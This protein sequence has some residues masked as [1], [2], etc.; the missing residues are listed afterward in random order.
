M[1]IFVSLFV[2]GFRRFACEAESSGVGQTM[3]KLQPHCVS[4]RGRCSRFRDVL[5]CERI[6]PRVVVSFA[7]P[8]VIALPQNHECLP[9][10]I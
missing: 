3:P 7:M 4:L 1:D 6:V 8:S 10:S 2:V 5:A 9:V